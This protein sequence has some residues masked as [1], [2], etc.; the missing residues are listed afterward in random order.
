MKGSLVTVVLIGAETC[1]DQWVR[2]QIQ[3]THARGDAFIGI[4]IHNVVS[5]EE[6]GSQKGSLYFGALGR[7]GKSREAY[8]S[9]FATMYDWRDESG[10]TELGKWIECARTRSMNVHD[11]GHPRDGLLAGKGCLRRELRKFEGQDR[12]QPAEHVSKPYSK[13]AQGRSSW[14]PVIVG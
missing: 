7:D 3:K 1:A 4:Y 6:P 9:Q 8:F 2:Y 13:S 14:N 11:A 12:L 5:S 10:V